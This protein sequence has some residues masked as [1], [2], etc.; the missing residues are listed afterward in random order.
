MNIQLLQETCV[1]ADFKSYAALLV[2]CLSGCQVGPDYEAP[3]PQTLVPDVY[4]QSAAESMRGGWVDPDHSVE[5]AQE[6]SRWWESLGDPALSAL[7]H[8]ALEHN[9]DLAAARERIVETR[10]RR[11]IENAER[12]PT[13]DG[14]AGYTYTDVGDD[15]TS[16]L[17]APGGVQRDTYSAGVV[18]GWELD[19]WGRVARLV[20]A[21][22]AQVEFAVE[23]YRAARVSLIAEVARE[24]VVARA[25][26]EELA[27]V[28]EGIVT[29]E[30]ALS[31]A[32]ARLDAG[33]ADELD[34]SRAKRTLERDR[35][36]LHVL[37]GQRRAAELRLAV[38]LGAAPGSI[39]VSV[40]ELPRRDITPVLG[41]PADLLL[42]RPD[43]RR[44]ERQLATASARIGAAQAEHYPRVSLSGSLLLGGPDI[45]DAVNP[46]TFLLS[47]GPALSIP[48]LDGNRIGSSIQAAE[49]LERQALLELRHATLR[50]LNE[51][52][53]AITDHRSTRRSADD[54]L[55]AEAAASDTQSLATQRYRAGV[56]DFLDVTE[57]NTQRLVIRRERLAS[58]RDTTLALIDLYVALGGG[59]SDVTQ[60]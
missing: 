4:P 8:L 13:L 27:A 56:T 40:G 11:G 38:L 15:N 20:Q 46:E 1:A 42:R 17:G 48:L 12:L 29:D 19:L 30:D 33:L 57:A 41:V 32:V 43:L 37:Q 7:I 2:L 23:D 31:I 3:A 18:A 52:E 26:D 36:A 51:V 6:L 34:T 45:G 25:L 54:L 44:S 10:A 14:T 24:F 28:R 58:E 5:Q 35:A 50:A 53:S 21:A 16:V 9:L 22:D 49:S 39:D 59:W 60:E 55:S 47:V